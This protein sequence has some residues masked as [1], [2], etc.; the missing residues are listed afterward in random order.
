M[1][2]SE[3]EENS[4]NGREVQ[5]PVISTSLTVSAAGCD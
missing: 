2:V 5:S 3:E 4:V 1:C